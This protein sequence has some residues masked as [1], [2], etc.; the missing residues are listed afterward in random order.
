MAQR[1]LRVAV[2]GATG[3]LGTELLGVLDQRRFPLG[4]LIP[5]ASDRSLGEVIEFRDDVFGVETEPHALRGVDFV[6]LAAPPETG[7]AYLRRALEAEVPCVDA[8][9]VLAGLSEVPLA[10]ADLG[11]S[12]EVARSPVLCSPPAPALAWSLVLAPLHRAARVLRVVG[13]ALDGASGGG[14]RGIASLGSES[15]ALFNQS[16]LPEPEVFEAPLAFDC[17]PT[18]TPAA[19]AEG[20]TAAEDRLSA[21]LQRLV[22]PELRIGVTELRVPVFVGDGASLAVELGEALSPAQAQAVLEKA[23]GVEV[24]AHDRFGPTTRAT[25]GREQVLVG[26]LRADPSAERGLLLWIA[27]DSLRLAASNAVRLAEAMLEARGA[28][29]S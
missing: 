25:A 27:A 22:S 1:A 6:F 5:I 26:R 18:T 7:L 13:T 14:R 3:A 29:T 2:A 15:I 12:R 10:V 17:H 20:A 11:L 8:S 4:E 9:G 23:P 21:A 24:W 16:D 28:L 19:G